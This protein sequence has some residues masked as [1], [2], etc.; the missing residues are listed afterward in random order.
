MESRR[1]FSL[2]SLFIELTL[3]AALIG[4]I[5]LTFLRPADP[6]DS[7]GVV[8]SLAAFCT[9]PVLVGAVIGGLSGRFIA[10]AYWGAG[11]L[12]VLFVL[13]L[14]TFPTVQ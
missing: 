7:L 5:R 9:V 8:L 10:G 2:R 6:N 13:A 1:Q 12:G 4:A 11:V 14:L 3:I